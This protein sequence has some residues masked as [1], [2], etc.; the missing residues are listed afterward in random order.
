MTSVS[1]WSPERQDSVMQS[2]GL[3]ADLLTENMKPYS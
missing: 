3:K 1:H 2:E